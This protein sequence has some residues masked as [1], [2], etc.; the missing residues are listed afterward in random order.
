MGSA[1]GASSEDAAA[2]AG[3]KW[4]PPTRADD[5]D[6]DDDEAAAMRERRALKLGAAQRAAALGVSGATK[7]PAKR[8][9][10]PRV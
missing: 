3:E 9:R 2:G 6:D 4:T 1:E 7:A 8:L 5:D 10:D